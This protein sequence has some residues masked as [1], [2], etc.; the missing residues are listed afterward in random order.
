MLFSK[1]TRFSVCEKQIKEDILSESGTIVLKLN[2]KYP[3]ITC[4]KRDPL[5][6]NAAPFYP[7]LAEGF[8]YYARADLK[9]AAL[10][11]FNASP[12]S[13]T[14]FSAVMRWE[15]TFED[16]RYISFLIDI[17]V[18]DGALPPITERKT[19]V[20]ERKFGTKCKI[21][22]F[23]NK[24]DVDNIINDYIGDENKKRFE[25]ELFTLSQD[26]L[27]FYLRT[28]NGFDAIK[29]PYAVSKQ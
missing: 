21:G 10:A 12:E 7:R 14:P 8:A 25:R 5:L 9:K 18:S 22:Q 3:N 1:K 20:W 2:L 29:V 27:V 15:K 28:K 17:L 11:A 23:F 4:P 13:F 24:K 26:G 6:Q 19:Q 16:E